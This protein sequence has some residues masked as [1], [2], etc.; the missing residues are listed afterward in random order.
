[1]KI[2][3]HI[4]EENN[5]EVFKRLPDNRDVLEARIS[6]LIASMT[7]R[8]I[9]NPIIVNEKMEVIDG[10]GRFEARKAMGVPIHYIVVP[11]ATAD[12]CRRMN[13]YNT[14]WTQLD[15]AKSYAKKGYEAYQL[16][17]KGCKDFALPISTILRLSNHSSRPSHNKN[18]MTI[19][20]RGELEFSQNDYETVEKC[21]NISND[22]INALQYTGRINDAFRTGIKIVCE[23]E[24]YNH[25]RMIKNCK[26]SRSSYVQMG[27]IGDQLI[28]FERIYNKYS[29]GNNVYF[30][31]YMRNRGE[32]VRDYDK[33]YSVYDD[34]DVSTLPF[35]E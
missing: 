19:F 12:D 29:K 8:Y 13:K 11:G 30:S 31:D 20:E 6:K 16:L 15:F 10:Q 26:K 35:I 9:C 27:K 34:K 25:Q 7:E 21:T 24:G 28:E 3:G 14:K 2:I 22:I 1:M 5:Y 4:Y 33:T 32:S 23:T 17:L 18:I